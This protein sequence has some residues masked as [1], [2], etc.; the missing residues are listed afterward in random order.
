V[1]YIGLA[2][3]TSST[4]SRIILVFY[5]YFSTSEGVCMED[6]LVTYQGSYKQNR[7]TVLK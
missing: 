6:Q 2:I 3:R 7:T 4:P 5:L 1:F